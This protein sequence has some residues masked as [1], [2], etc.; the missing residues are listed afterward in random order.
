[1][2]SLSRYVSGYALQKLAR[3]DGKHAEGVAYVIMAKNRQQSRLNEDATSF[4]RLKKTSPA[5]LTGSMSPPDR[6]S[7]PVDNRQR[8]RSQ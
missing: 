2:M 3:L 6:T 1:M 8:A 4:A 7:A 5:Q